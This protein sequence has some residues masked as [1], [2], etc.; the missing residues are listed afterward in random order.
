TY[1][2]LWSSSGHSGP[3]VSLDMSASSNKKTH[4][5]SEAIFFLSASAYFAL[6]SFLPCLGNQSGGS[7]TPA[8]EGLRAQADHGLRPALL[9]YAGT[10]LGMLF[11]WTSSLFLM[12]LTMPPILKVVLLR[13]S[14][15]EYVQST[16]SGLKGYQEKFASLTGLES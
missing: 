12:G 9:L 10:S 5:I 2:P 3:D 8:A 15:H 6:D 14:H 7:A 16:Y 11:T 4:T 13:A 1:Q